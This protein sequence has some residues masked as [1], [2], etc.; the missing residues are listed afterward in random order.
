MCFQ[1]FHLLNALQF[2]FGCRKCIGFSNNFFRCHVAP[3]HPHEEQSTG[4]LFEN[5]NACDKHSVINNRIRIKICLLL[6]GLWYAHLMAQSGLRTPMLWQMPSG[7]FR[8][9]S[10]W[11]PITW[12]LC[13]IQ[14]CMRKPLSRPWSNTGTCL[15][16][17]LWS[18]QWHFTTT[19]RSSTRNL[20]RV[21]MIAET[22]RSRAC[23][24]S[25]PTMQIAL[26]TRQMQWRKA[27]WGLALWSK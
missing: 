2:T 9:Y 1:A 24:D 19:C 13:S 20:T 3:T 10:E 8:S 4:K 14:P 6:A 5:C 22:C 23:V 16:S 18:S 15:T 7:S 17:S 21:A 11:A 26:F 27:S 12:P 25:T